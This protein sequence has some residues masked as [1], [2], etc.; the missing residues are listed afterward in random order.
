MNTFIRL[1]ASVA[2]FLI[3]V[4]AVFA[5]KQIKTELTEPADSLLYQTIYLKDSLLF[6]AFNT[7]NFQKF[8]SFFS[9]NLE[10]YQDNTGVRN[11]QQSMEAFNGLFKG[12]YILTR[13]LVKESLEVYPIK[14]FGAIETGQHTFCHIENGKTDCG[15]FKFVHIWQNENGTWKITRIITYNH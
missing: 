15:T 12:N 5:K 7:R 8:Q 13:T 3:I 2:V 1:L 6:D 9:P 10:I 4:Q 14:D 11:F